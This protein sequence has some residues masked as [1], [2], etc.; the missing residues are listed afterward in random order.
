MYVRFVR[1]SACCADGSA[2]P[3][4]IAAERPRDMMDVADVHA[5]IADAISLL[6]SLSAQRCGAGESANITAVVSCPS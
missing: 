2:F 6:H 1:R 4:R 5:N 3:R